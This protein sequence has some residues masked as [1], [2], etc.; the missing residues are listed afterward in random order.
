V[1]GSSQQHLGA[2]QQEREQQRA[3]TNRYEGV[4]ASA[5]Q[6]R[7]QAEE[8][9]AQYLDVST[10]DLDCSPA[11]ISTDPHAYSECRRSRAVNKYETHRLHGAEEQLLEQET[12]VDSGVETVLAVAEGSADTSVELR[13]M[14]YK[15]ACS[16]PTGQEQ[17]KNPRNQQ[18]Y[19]SRRYFKNAAN[20]PATLDA[21]LPQPQRDVKVRGLAALLYA[22]DQHDVC[23]CLMCMTL[24]RLMQEVL[25]FYLRTLCTSQCD[26][27]RLVI[28]LLEVLNTCL[29]LP[30]SCG[31]QHAAVSRLTF[32]FHISHHHRHSGRQAKRRRTTIDGQIVICCAQATSVTTTA[33]GL[34][35]SV[36]GSTRLWATLLVLLVTCWFMDDLAACGNA[37]LLAASAP[38]RAWCGK[39]LSRRTRGEACADLDSPAW[40]INATFNLA[41]AWLGDE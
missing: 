20:T 17:Y 9:A 14:Y 34:L 8:A 7:R 13:R 40:L 23:H 26:G 22:G 27:G 24:V 4:H 16:G 18:H 33:G 5:W 28:A 3:L 15:T 35:W 37:W 32:W 1:I 11:G 10:L 25:E 41:D 19:A 39:T 30:V 12:A 21:L 31:W 29:G 38:V 2:T 6:Y 36:L